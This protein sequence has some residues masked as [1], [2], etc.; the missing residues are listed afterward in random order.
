MCLR[1]YARLKDAVE[2]RIK[3]EQIALPDSPLLQLVLSHMEHLV[4]EQK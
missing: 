3:G 4:L 2:R 1:S